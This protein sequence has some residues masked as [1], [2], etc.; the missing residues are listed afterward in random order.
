MG[1][2]LVFGAKGCEFESHPLELG[3]R[4]DPPPLLWLLG[5]LILYGVLLY[6]Y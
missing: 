2:A 1:M 6:F 5:L 3:I 4:L